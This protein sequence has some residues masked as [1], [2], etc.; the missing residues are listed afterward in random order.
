MKKLYTLLA[1]IV[2][3]TITAQAPQGFNYQATVRNAAGDLIINQNVTFK[4]NIMLN[5]STSLP[6]FSET[7]YVP[8]DDLGQVN[9]TVGTGT[10]TTGTF[11][12]INWANGTYFLGIEL[13]TG[14]GYVAMGTTQLLSVPY[15]LYANSSGNSQSLSK[16]SIYLT[17]DITDA[18]AAA[19]IANEFGS[20]TEN[21][22]IKNTTQLTTVDLNSLVTA[23]TIKIENNIALI[24]L[25]L[26]GLTTV[27]NDIDAYNNPLLNLTLQ[28]LTDCGDKINIYIL[29]TLNLPNL[30]KCK[31]IQFSQINN[32]TPPSNLTRCNFISIHEMP[33]L[34]SLSFSSLTTCDSMNIEN[35][36]YLTSLS[37]SSLTTCD[38]MN[39]QN[40]HLFSSLS[41]AALT[42][43]YTLNL[44]SNALSSTNIN[45]LLNQML[46]ILP[47]T[48]KTIYLNNQNPLA[49]PSGQGVVDKQILIDAGNFVY[50]DE[51]IPTLTTTAVNLI[52]SSTASCGGNITDNGGSSITA[53]GVVWSTSNN[54][55]TAN[56]IGITSNGGGEGVFTSN[57]LNLTLATT[58]YVR[59]Y[60]TNNSGT[61]YGN[62]IIFSALPVLP[63]LTTIPVSVTAMTSAHSGGIISSNGGGAISSSGVCWSTSPNPTI[64]LSTKTVDDSGYSSG[65]GYIV[66]NSS[67]TG[68]IPLTT[69]YL[70][71]YA[72]NVIG[73]A[74]GQEEIF[75]SQTPISCSLGYVTIN[76]QI[77]SGCNVDVTTY[78]D[79]TPIPQV[80][81]PTAWANLTTGAWCYYNNDQANGAIYGKL[82]NFYALIGIHD[83]NPNTPNKRLAPTGWHVPSNTD[84]GALTNYLGGAVA[85]GK[86]KETGTTHWTTPNTGA[87]NESGFTGLPGGYRDLNGISTGIR[88]NGSWWSYSF[89]SGSYGYNRT[90]DFN[91]EYV[92]ASYNNFWTY[93]F[94]V[95]FV[96]D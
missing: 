17:G 85:G 88:T 54:P 26:N 61:A 35:N 60:A 86:M 22:Y 5:T 83:D 20:N 53:R 71:A 16:T 56:N 72:T 80:T 24:N 63:T 64:A 66:F 19:K 77:W 51:F 78:S 18:Q 94:S 67:I 36:P 70:R 65:G 68:L 75:T 41:F 92:Q 43:V 49:P 32:F 4:F 76:N 79:G 1:L 28:S 12:S 42:N 3:T 7:H 84:W 46:I 47:L 37:F 89:I 11:S 2:L 44:N 39:I 10:S 82:Y 58:Y 6:V 57:I 74:Y 95:R 8:T 96:K 15:A 34:T 50:T 31:Q 55:T 73:T 87:T 13:N 52:T 25:N 45:S 21:I 40:N 62:Q 33:Y 91:S 27:Y 69:Y 38:N 23:V 9:L 59:A 14:S 30:L 93:G 81:D 48:G 29:S 90:L